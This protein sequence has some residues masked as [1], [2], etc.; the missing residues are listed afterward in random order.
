MVHA[1]EEF[2]LVMS[3]R[4]L[5]HIEDRDFVLEEGDSLTFKSA[6]PH[7][8]QNLHEGQSVIMWVVSPAPNVVQ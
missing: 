4:M 8:W 7:R 1:G 6:L 3:G 5:F 2:A